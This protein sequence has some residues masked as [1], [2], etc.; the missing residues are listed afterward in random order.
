MSVSI[1]CIL[2]KIV[3]NLVFF[4]NIIYEYGSK[5]K[6]E[7]VKSPLGI[8][9]ACACKNLIIFVKVKETN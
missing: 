8:K 6:F 7:N 2:D 1:T 3:C 4:F 9:G 5:N